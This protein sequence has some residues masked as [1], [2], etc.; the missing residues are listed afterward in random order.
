VDY[1][2]SLA[3]K[4]TAAG[5]VRVR[6]HEQT[7]LDAVE[8][9]ATG[10]QVVVRYAFLNRSYTKNRSGAVVSAAIDKPAEVEITL[11]KTDGAWVVQQ[12]FAGKETLE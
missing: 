4:N 6:V 8:M 11:R 12:M 2:R 1:Y 7:S 10:Q 9:D 5:L 3:D